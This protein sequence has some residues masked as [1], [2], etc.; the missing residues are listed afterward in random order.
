MEIPEKGQHLKYLRNG[1]IF[2]VKKVTP[3]F[4]ILHDKVGLMQIITGVHNVFNL[5]EKLPAEDQ[6]KNGETNLT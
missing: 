1:E 5:F 2:E 3:E 4:V 6:Q